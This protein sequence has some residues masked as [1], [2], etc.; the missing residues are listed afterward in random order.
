MKKLFILLGLFFAFNIASQAQ[1]ITI[2]EKDMGFVS[3]SASST[4]E[5]LPD[6][7]SIRFAVDTTAVES[8]DAVSKNK[9]MSA[10]LM[11]SLKQ[12]L[13]TDKN[14]IIQTK[15]FVLKPNYKTDKNGNKTFLNYTA[16]NI[17]YVKTKNIDNVA[18]LIDAGTANN[19]SSISELHFYVE[20]LKQFEGQL[21]KEALS[22]AQIIADLTASTLG[23]KVKGIRSVRVNIYPQGSASAYGVLSASSNSTQAT[24]I[25]YGKI[26]LQANVNA[27]FY[28]K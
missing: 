3:V 2:V 28:V 8:K 14:D 18:K 23:Q 17:I 5:V 19:A 7:A 1:A 10:K 9:E 22:N 13:A 6:T 15:S 20:N 4:K 21:A 16:T 25:E 11:D 27:E 24:P 26:K 12:Q